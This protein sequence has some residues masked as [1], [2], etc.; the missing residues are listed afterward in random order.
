MMHLFHISQ[1]TIQNRNVH[2]SVLNGALWDMEQVH[3]G[4]CEIGL[5]HGCTHVGCASL[6][7]DIECNIIYINN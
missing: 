3:C 6:T 7:Q 2:I 1:C 4:V 5:S